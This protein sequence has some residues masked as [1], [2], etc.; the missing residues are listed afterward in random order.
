MIA[1]I[2]R[3]QKPTNI[4]ISISK[5]FTN[6]GYI[7]TIRTNLKRGGAHESNNKKRL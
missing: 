7:E 6:L 5:N 2:T 4:K 3:A 1:V